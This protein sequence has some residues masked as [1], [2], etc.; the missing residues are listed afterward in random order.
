LISAASGR[1]ISHAYDA[2]SQNGSI[3]MLARVLSKT[4]PNAKGKVTFVLAVSD[5]EMK[6]L[7]SGIEVER[8]GVNTAYG[9]DEECEYIS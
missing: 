1:E 5:E 2:V 3:L 9:E 8:T 6:Q 4:S 7:P